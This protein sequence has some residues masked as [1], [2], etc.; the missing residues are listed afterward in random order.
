MPAVRDSPFHFVD[1]LAVR[2][3]GRRPVKAY[4]SSPGSVLPEFS[5][6]DD[7]GDVNHVCVLG[8]RRSGYSRPA[9]S[10]TISN[11]E[12]HRRNELTEDVHHDLGVRLIE[13]LIPITSRSRV[14]LR[15]GDVSGCWIIRVHWLSESLVDYLVQIAIHHA[16]PR[17]N[18]LGRIGRDL[19]CDS[20][21]W[22]SSF[23]DAATYFIRKSAARSSAPGDGTPK[24]SRGNS[25]RVFINLTISSTH[26]LSPPNQRPSILAMDQGAKSIPGIVSS[27]D[28]RSKP[29]PLH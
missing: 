10:S 4:A 19:D 13:P 23:L 27:T 12:V 14:R 15:F 3:P 20:P 7:K 16:T 1:W 18:A 26:I 11:C 17:W 9:T 8:S 28:C 6:F 22:F 2:Q 25:A 21:S 29:C 24:V 5:S